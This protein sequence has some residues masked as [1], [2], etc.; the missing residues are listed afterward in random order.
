MWARVVEAMIGCWLA[1]SPFIFAHPAD[2]EALWINDLACAF[3]VVVLALASY[4]RSF[5]QAHLGI[6]AVGLWLT[7][8]GYFFAAGT[9]QPALQNDLVVGLLLLMVAIIPNYASLPPRGWMEYFEQAE[10]ASGERLPGDRVEHVYG[11][12]T[13]QEESDQI[14]LGR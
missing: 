13:A 8:F 6:L 14:P 5:R 3:A 7:G 12:R 1:M 4:A 11:D 10:T 2:R 9:P